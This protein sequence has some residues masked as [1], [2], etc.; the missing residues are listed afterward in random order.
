[1][2]RKMTS[3]RTPQRGKPRTYTGWACVYANCANVQLTLYTSKREAQH[4]GLE[5]GDKLVRVTVKEVK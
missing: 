1:M 5:R 3:S 2:R 4:D